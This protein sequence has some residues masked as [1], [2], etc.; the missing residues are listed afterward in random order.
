MAPSATRRWVY[1][2]FP[3]L[4]AVAS[5]ALF[6]T[7]AIGYKAF[8]A[9]VNHYTFQTSTFDIM[10]VRPSRYVSLLFFFFFSLV[11]FPK[12]NQHLLSALSLSSAATL[13]LLSLL[14]V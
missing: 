12:F 3:L 5:T 8:S 11:T 9:E 13:T 14:I 10:V 1:V 4:V 2:L 6:L 7:L